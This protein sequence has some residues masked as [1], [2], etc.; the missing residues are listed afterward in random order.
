MLT[1]RVPRGEDL[2]CLER[3]HEQTSCRSPTT[4]MPGMKVDLKRRQSAPLNLSDTPAYGIGLHPSQEGV[5]VSTSAQISRLPRTRGCNGVPCA[6]GGTRGRC[7][8]TDRAKWHWSDRVRRQYRS[9][10]R[11]I[12]RF[13]VDTSWRSCESL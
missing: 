12:L 13:G 5:I 4:T 11:T 3:Q 1:S 6:A 9:R 10:D 8:E 7:V 2:L